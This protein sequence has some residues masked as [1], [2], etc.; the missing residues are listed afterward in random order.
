VKDFDP[1][2]FPLSRIHAVALSLAIIVGV[3]GSLSAQ[4]A[5]SIR[6]SDQTGAVIA[7]ATVQ[8]RSANG[9]VQRTTQ[10]DTTGSSNISGLAAGNYRLVVSNPGF[11]SK[12]IPFTI[13]TAGV[14]LAVIRKRSFS[15]IGRQ[16]LCGLA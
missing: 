6:I 1:K 9:N 16:G 7:G 14:L 4:Q 3:P 13:G 10:S 15:V 11:E 12:E 8:V 2:A 5:V